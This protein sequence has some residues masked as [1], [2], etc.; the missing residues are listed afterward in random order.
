MMTMVKTMKWSWWKRPVR[1]LRQ[2]LFF[3]PHLSPCRTT[4]K[5][6]DEIPNTKIKLD[7]PNKPD[8]L[9]KSLKESKRGLKKQFWS[10]QLWF[11]EHSF[12]GQWSVKWWILD[13]CDWLGKVNNNIRRRRSFK[14]KATA[15]SRVGFKAHF[16][17]IRLC[18]EV[19]LA[20]TPIIC[21]SQIIFSNA[22]LQLYIT[23]SHISKND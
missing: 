14:A 12:W 13:A 11:K 10:R 7:L 17:I 3:P 21:S 18:R 16:H 19:C 6:T 15:E 2:L 22:T 5:N 4:P 1:G 8:S 9:F 23:N 20:L